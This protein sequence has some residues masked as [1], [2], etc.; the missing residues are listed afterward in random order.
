MTSDSTSRRFAACQEIPRVSQRRNSSDPRIKPRLKPGHNLGVVTISCL[1]ISAARCAR[2][3]SS[4]PSRVM[5]IR[6][7]RAAGRAVTRKSFYCRVYFIIEIFARRQRR[8]TAAV[9]I[10]LII[11]NTGIP[12][13]SVTISVATATP[14]QH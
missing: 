4:P 11:I 14:R 5:T 6:R 3:K 1:S 2:Y 10:R 9:E 12:V 7:R 13:K 8:P